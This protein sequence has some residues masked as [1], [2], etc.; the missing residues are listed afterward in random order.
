MQVL[1]AVVRHDSCAAIGVPHSYVAPSLPHSLKTQPPQ[2]SHD[3]SGPKHRKARHPSSGLDLDSLNPDDIGRI[4]RII[5]L[6]QIIE[7]QQNDLFNVRHQLIECVPIAVTTL[8]LWHFAQIAPVL[9][10]FDDYIEFA[11]CHPNS[12]LVL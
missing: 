5:I 8:E 3:L 4:I 10:P 1:G 9:G 6:R 2:T 11:L 7:A 12:P